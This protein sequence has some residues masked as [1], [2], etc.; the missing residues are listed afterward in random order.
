MWRRAAE[1]GEQW[2]VRETKLTKRPSHVQPELVEGGLGARPVV[3]VCPEICHTPRS[4]LRIS[5][6]VPQVDNEVVA[7]HQFLVVWRGVAEHNHSSVKQICSQGE[8]ARHDS[9]EPVVDNLSKSLQ[10]PLLLTELHQIASE[11]PPG[12]TLSCKWGCLPLIC[13]KLEQAAVGQKVKANK[14]I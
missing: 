5:T 3:Q 2:E 11:I 4:C 13:N 9:P 14:G 6:Q 8:G 7:G 12:S 10:E 1:A